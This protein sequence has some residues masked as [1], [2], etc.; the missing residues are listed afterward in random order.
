M[1]L[2]ALVRNVRETVLMSRLAV[3]ASRRLD[4]VNLALVMAALASFNVSGAD[5]EDEEN[6]PMVRDKDFI[7]DISRELEVRAGRRWETPGLLSLLQLAWSMSLAGLR[8]G[9]V[10]ASHAVSHLEE[11]EMFV[12]MALENRVFHSL[13]GLILSASAFAKEEFYQRR[14]HTIITDFLT[15]MPLKIKEL[16]NRADDSARNAVMHEQEGVQYTVP[17]AG[18]HFSQLLA[19]IS[20]LYAGDKLDL[21]LADL[22]WCSTELATPLPRQAGGG[23]GGITNAMNVRCICWNVVE[24]R[25]IFE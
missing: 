14:L 23:G 2:H 13:P 10:A 16:R 22:Y 5:T 4:D 24:I 8:S 20:S 3:A 12:D 15:L 1:A 17:L 21:G 25:L 18:Q 7:A 11:D 6:V 9:A 19:T